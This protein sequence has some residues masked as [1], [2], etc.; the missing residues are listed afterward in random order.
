MTG[1]AVLAFSQSRSLS[2]SLLIVPVAG[3]GMMT[4]FAA[5][6][7]IIQTLVDDRMRGRV[8]AIFGMAVLGMAPF[9]ALLGG[10]LAKA[11]SPDPLTGASR[12]LVFSGCAVLAASVAYVTQLPASRRA[13]RPV[14]VARGILPAVADADP[15]TGTAAAQ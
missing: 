3:W 4:C 2:L 5:A 6:N 8:M 12:T 13:A 11:F 14:Y 10:H 15:A 9:G 7:T 1:L